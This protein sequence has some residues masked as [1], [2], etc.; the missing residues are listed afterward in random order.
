M[1][2]DDIP[3]RIERFERTVA[4]C[5]CAVPL[6]FSA[7][8]V[9]AAFSAPTFGAMFADFG[10][11]LPLPTQ[12]ILDTWGLWAAF[13]IIVPIGCFTLARRGS[14][15]LSVILSTILGV[16]IFL[17]AQLITG[18]LLLPVFHLGAVAGGI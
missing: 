6:L 8:C 9:L 16:A 5:L 3:K 11:K 18:A 13:G 7:Q 4:T 17:I 10:A 15:N 12:F 14:P 1:N 2:T